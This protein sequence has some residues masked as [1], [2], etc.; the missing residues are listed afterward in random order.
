MEKI[1][2]VA[3]VGPE[4]TGKSATSAFLA[5]QFN[6]LWVPEYAREYCSALDR[7]ASLE[8]EINMFHGQLKL[9]QN[10]IQ[11]STKPLLI[12]DTTILNVKIWCDYVFHQ[13]PDFIVDEIHHH[14]YDLY[15]LMD[16]DLPWED[17]PLRNFKDKR[18][19]FFEIFQKELR[20]LR[21]T[22]EVVTGLENDRFFRALE[23]V[24]HYFPY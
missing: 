12:C 19:V 2:K 15:L 17:D 14:P 22:F 9:E 10:Y 11:A 21:A 24:Q 23:I 8:D 7:E 18:S 4:S 13:T 16:I 6:C 20:D 3:V 5:E 1:F